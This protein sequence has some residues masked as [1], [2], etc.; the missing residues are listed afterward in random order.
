L[1]NP[2][3]IGI[4]TTPHDRLSDERQAMSMTTN[5][6]SDGKPQNPTT[7]AAWLSQQCPYCTSL[8]SDGFVG[9]IAD[10]GLDGGAGGMIH[11]DFGNRVRFGTSYAPGDP[12]TSDGYGHGTLVAGFIASDASR[13]SV[14]LSGYYMGMGIAPSAGVF[15]TKIVNGVG[16]TD[17]LHNIWTWASD[18]RFAIPPVLFQNHS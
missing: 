13:G 8:N 10:S 16:N 2:L 12:T 1:E 15:S 11:P 17:S 14:D 4:A 18:A 5:V 6:T 7:Y 3:I 9:G